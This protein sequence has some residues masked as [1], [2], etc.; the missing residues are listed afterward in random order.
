MTLFKGVE[1]KSKKNYLQIHSA[2]QGNLLLVQN[3]NTIYFQIGL[4]NKDIL[5]RWDGV[6]VFLNI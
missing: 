6:T 5:L 1:E 3:R 4:E 2:P